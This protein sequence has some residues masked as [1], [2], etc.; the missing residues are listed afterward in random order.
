[1]EALTEPLNSKKQTESS[2]EYEGVSHELEF[3]EPVLQM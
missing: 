2:E 1:M 3:T